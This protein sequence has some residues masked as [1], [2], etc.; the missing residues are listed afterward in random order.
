M[1]KMLRTNSDRL[2]YSEMLIPPVGYK[3]AFAIGTTYSLDLEA[4]IGVS[5]SLGLNEDID[6]KLSDSPI[7]LLEALRKVAD[8]MLIFCEAGQIKAPAT[9]N[10]LFPF[11]ENSVV[12][13]TAKNNKSFHPK[14]W[15]VKYEN[16]NA[17]VIYRILVLSRNLTFDRSWD[18][19]ICMDGKPTGEAVSKNESLVA[20]MTYLYERMENRYEKMAVK[21]RSLKKL[22]D[23]FLQIEF[24]L[25]DKHFD[26]FY[27]I[28]LGIY[29]GYN[30]EYTELFNTY[31]KLLVISPFLSKNIMD[32]FK[33]LQLTNADKTL[34]T[35]KS[36]LYKLSKDFLQN[37]DT[38]TLKD[39]VVDGEDR[40][41]EEGEIKKQDI[42]AKLYLRTKDSYSELF[43]GSANASENAFN[44]NIEFMVSIAAKRRWLNVENLKND[45]FGNDDKINPFEKIKAIDYVV[46]DADDAKEDLQKAIKEFCK[47]KTLATVSDGYNIT[48]TIGKLKT[49]IELFISPLLITKRERVQD[50]VIFRGLD[51]PQLSEFYVVTT[52]KGGEELSRVVKIKTD[53]IP[54]DRDSS[55]FNSI[56]RNKEGFIQYI[57][58]LLG[59]DYLLTFIEDGA[60]KG[61]EYKFLTAN[62]QETPVLYEKMLKAAARSPE[63]LN[64]IKQV[65]TMITDKDIIPEHF[66]ALYNTF[67]KAVL[68]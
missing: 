53:G 61:N 29:E 13:V 40:L 48:I 60:K 7:Y 44:G 25:N 3:T 64:E 15:L 27:F 41:A 16:D 23:E 33:R 66:H 28:P 31:H 39:D 4:L 38:Y 59:D 45:L 67:E 17:E 46:S 63:K 20:F 35:R 47:V 42:H 19:A 49:D 8:K 58:F 11:L 22:L 21:K 5:I 26:D 36:E 14:V 6:S 57:S 51:L 2:D 62:C 30:K 55:I 52:R 32:E 65:M 1:S 10:K 12:M 50:T 43:L 54:D 18:V 68:K 56:I 37:F 34:I 24:Q 9:Q